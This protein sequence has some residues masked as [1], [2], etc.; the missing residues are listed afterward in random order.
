[1]PIANKYKLKD[2]TKALIYYYEKT[3][4]RITFE[5]TVIEGLNDGDSEAKEI[6]RLCQG[7]LAHVNLIAL[8]PIKEFDKQRP[9][10]KTVVL[11]EQKLLKLGI[12]T[13]IRA[14]KGLDISASCGQLRR[15]VLNDLI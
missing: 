11:F 8:N 2:L 1:M 14:E 3:N 4:R 6:A 12:Q 5:Y 7:F 10:K 9:S 13:T 15:S